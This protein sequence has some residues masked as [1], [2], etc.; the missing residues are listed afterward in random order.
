MT[1]HKYHVNPLIMLIMVLTFSCSSYERDNELDS[2]AGSHYK[3]DSSSSLGSLSSSGN[4][5]PSSSSAEGNSSSSVA[6]S[7][8]GDAGDSSSSSSVTTESSSSILS[9]SS[10]GSS[11]SSSSEES[12]SSVTLCGTESYDPVTHFCYLNTPPALLFCG[13]EKK[14]YNPV[15]QRCNYGTLQTKCGSNWYDPENEFCYNYDT[16][17]PLC[18]TRSYTTT[19]FCR[20]NQVF[21]KCDGNI[22]EYNLNQFCDADDIVR[23]KCGSTPTGAIYNPNTETCCGS[24]KYTISSQFCSEQ[25]TQVY[26]KCGGDTYNTTTEACCGGSGASGNKYTISS[27]FCSSTTILA[28][29]GG[30]TYTPT[31]EACCGSGASG[32]KYT[33]SSQFCSEQ[34][35]QVYSKCNN[36]PYNTNTHV[37]DD[38][39]LKYFFKD[40]RDQKIY[41]YVKIDNIYWMAENL[42]YKTGTSKCYAEGASGVTADSSAKNCVKYGLLYDWTTASTAC[43]TGW[44]LPSEGYWYALRV[45]VQEDNGCSMLNPCEANY[46]RIDYWSTGTDKYGFKALPGGWYNSATNGFSAEGSS[47]MFWTSTASSDY[48]TWY[49]MPGY[50]EMQTNNIK[51]DNMVYVRCAKIAE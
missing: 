2:K 45:F 5:E 50:G 48:A 21:D 6:L 36:F 18:G 11:S 13:T 12:S 9:S 51:K 3:G 42:N 29:C 16:P 24:A 22:T 46:L 35:T 39:F 30:N 32:N 4:T 7:S 17:K 8:S 41:K 31:T 20:E 34:D 26:S 19:Q 37:C 14:T 10:D 27:H 44:S 1:T 25:N 33:T 49:T 40:T 43:P 47:T 15:N 23:F 38:G 28:K